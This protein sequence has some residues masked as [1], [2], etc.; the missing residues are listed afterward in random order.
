MLIFE[1]FVLTGFYA[2]QIGIYI[3][4]FRDNL[5]VTDHQSTLLKSKKSEDSFTW[6]RKPEIT[7]LGICPQ[8][9]KEVTKILSKKA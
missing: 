6:R 2:V 4:A 9:K 1:I 3:P 5:S 7:H 8:G